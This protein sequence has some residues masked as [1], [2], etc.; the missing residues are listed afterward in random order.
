M[1]NF[2][3]GVDEAGKGP[4]ISSLIVCVAICDRQHEKSLKK[5]CKKDSKQLSAKQREETLQELNKFCTFKVVELTA[6]DLNTHMKT[7]SLNDI[8]ARAMA[9][10]L[11]NLTGDIMIDLLD[12]Y[13]WTFRAR[14]EKFGIKRFEAQHKADEN[15]PIVAAA[16][17]NAKVLRDKRVKEVIDATGIDFGSGYPSDPKTISALKNA[18]LQRKLRPYIRERWQ[19]LEN[20]KQKKLFEDES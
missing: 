4:V 9:S 11:K 8:E 15:F 17:I 5:W 13:E 12:R 2:L 1:S 16:S 7:M 10:L 18:E 3:I 19:T 20:I 6:A 14:M